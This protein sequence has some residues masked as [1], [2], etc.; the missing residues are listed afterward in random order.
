MSEDTFKTK[1]LSKHAISTF[2]LKVIYS[3]KKNQNDHKNVNN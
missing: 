2:F 3:T 1:K